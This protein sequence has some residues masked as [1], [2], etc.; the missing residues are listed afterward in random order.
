MV[1]WTLHDDRRLG[2]WTQQD[3]VA[4]GLGGLV[5]E[6]TVG[7]LGVGGG[8]RQERSGGMRLNHSGPLGWAQEAV[9]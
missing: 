3:S 4:H 8:D 5:R 9:G 7:T 1:S 6:I 2:R